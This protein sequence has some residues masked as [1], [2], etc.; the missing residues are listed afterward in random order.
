MLARPL[1]WCGY[2]I[3]E[4][5]FL[6]GLPRVGR[7]YTGT[8]GWGT[9]TALEHSRLRITPCHTSTAQLTAANRWF[10]CTCADSVKYAWTQNAPSAAASQRSDDRRAFHSAHAIAAPVSAM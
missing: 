10:S 1:F 6:T 4:F 7:F 9:P 8:D 3:F 2:A 5:G